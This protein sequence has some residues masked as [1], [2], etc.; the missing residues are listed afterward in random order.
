[1]ATKNTKHSAFI[2][3]PKGESSHDEHMD[4]EYIY[5]HRANEEYDMQREPA[6]NGH[7]V[8][9]KD[10]EKANKKRRDLTYGNS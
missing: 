1:M 2:L 9:D 10:F 7:C 4:T 6:D 8:D 5:G 3:K